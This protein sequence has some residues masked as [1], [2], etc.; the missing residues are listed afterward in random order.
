MF[1][2]QIN[3]KVEHDFSHTLS[4]IFLSNIFP[5]TTR[6]S[7]LLFGGLL[8][9]ATASIVGIAF[10]VFICNCRSNGWSRL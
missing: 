6:M 9:A 3:K 10:I 1:E 8:S 7:Q 2:K 5:N 4:K